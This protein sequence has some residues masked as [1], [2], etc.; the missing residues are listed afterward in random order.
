MGQDILAV[1][2]QTCSAPA[3]AVTSHFGN[4]PLI[5]WRARGVRGWTHLSVAGCTQASDQLSCLLVTPLRRFICKRALDEGGHMNTESAIPSGL[6]AQAVQGWVSLVSRVRC[7]PRG[8]DLLAWR[9]WTCL[10]DVWFLCSW[11]NCPCNGMSASS[12]SWGPLCSPKPAGSAVAGLWCC[13]IT[14]CLPKAV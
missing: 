9:P 14:Y 5:F 3:Q 4:A 12:A 13:R 1:P 8:I 10:G 6:W 2:L 11:G 7:R